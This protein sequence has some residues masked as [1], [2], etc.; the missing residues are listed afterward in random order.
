MEKR[1][2][3]VEMLVR[4][5]NLIHTLWMF[6]AFLVMSCSSEDDIV[7][8]V[9]RDGITFDVDSH[10]KFYETEDA[11]LHGVRFF[12][13]RQI[14]PDEIENI[15][16]EISGKYSLTGFSQM[17]TGSWEMAKFGNWASRYGVSPEAVYYVATEVYTKKLPLLPDGLMI[18]PNNHNEGMGFCPGIAAQTF[19][20]ENDYT[21]NSCVL[22]TG[23]RIIKYDINGNPINI[24]IN[25][26]K[27]QLTWKFQIQKDV[28]D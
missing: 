6:M 16:Y 19:I 13:G 23:N 28:W 5:Q 4:H 10:I 17:E 24:S 11:F 1:L 2:F 14:Q 20:Y 9:M 18:V 8:A 27:E 25:S 15:D 7:H 3:S 26:L 22:K 12:P 21:V